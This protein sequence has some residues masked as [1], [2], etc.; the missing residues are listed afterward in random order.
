MGDMLAELSSQSLAEKM[1]LV[2]QSPPTIDH[3]QLMSYDLQP[4]CQQYLSLKD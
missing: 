2:W 1:A 3:Q 4:I